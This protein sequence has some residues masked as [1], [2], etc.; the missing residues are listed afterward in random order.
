MGI[1]REWI[2]E[3]VDFEHSESTRRYADRAE[4]PFLHPSTVGFCRRKAILK[5]V[6]HF[7]DHPLHVDP[8][9]DGFD[10]Y[11]KQ[12]MREG[13]VWEK[14]NAP[15]FTKRGGIHGYI[16][17]LPPWSGEEDFYIP[18]THDG[19]DRMLVEHKVTAQWNFRASD[20]KTGRRRLP[21]EHHLIQVAVY[22]TL[23]EQIY[24]TTPQAVLYYMDGRDQ[25]AE[26]DIRLDGEIDY[27]GE[28]N[29]YFNAGIFDY[30]VPGEMKAIE[31]WW[32]AQE[33]P[34]TP[35]N[36]FKLP[37]NFGN[38]VRQNKS[39]TWP[40]CPWFDYC[41]PEWVSQDGNVVRIEAAS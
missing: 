30:D 31:A 8:T 5:T 37:T 32:T 20:K 17:R 35:R 9:W 33:L 38:C 6:E 40:A 26:F 13:T 34:P 12:A 7:P 2:E 28:I 4:E 39:G 29:G 1:V 19:V 11:V 3:Q 15:A 41:W 21:Y 22:I 18:E 23:Y 14:A 10:L 36:P 24:G 25:W 16:L 27:E